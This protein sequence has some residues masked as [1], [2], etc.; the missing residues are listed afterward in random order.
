MV[1][2]RLQALPNSDVQ[3][4]TI[5]HGLTD[6]LIYVCIIDGLSG[7]PNRD[8]DTHRSST[9]PVEQWSWKGLNNPGIKQSRAGAEEPRPRMQSINRDGT[10][11]G[12][13]SP[14]QGCRAST[15][16]STVTDYRV[17][18]YRPVLPSRCYFINRPSAA[19]EGVR[20]LRTSAEANR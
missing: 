19:D 6:S 11:L 5:L 9:R 13:K 1:L 2:G 15:E 18:G 10:V 4:K 7:L 16:A 3:C 17:R 8:V 12:L 14:A 20:T